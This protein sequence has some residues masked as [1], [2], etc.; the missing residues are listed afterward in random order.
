MVFKIWHEIN[1]I[2]FQGPEGMTHRVGEFRGVSVGKVKTL[3]FY[4]TWRPLFLTVLKPAASKRTGALGHHYSLRT[5]Q[6][7]L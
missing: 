1:S 2:T 3:R 4:F 7:I 6:S 5:E